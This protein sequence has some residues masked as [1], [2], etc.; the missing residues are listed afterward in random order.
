MAFLDLFK[1]LYLKDVKYN[2]DEQFL[3]DILKIK[4]ESYGHGPQQTIFPNCKITLTNK[5]II[6]SQKILWK[7][8][9]RVH[10]FIWIDN[11]QIVSTINKGMI[12]LCYDAEESSFNKEEFKLIP[13]DKTFITK[14][15]IY[16]CNTELKDFFHLK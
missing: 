3:S 16:K 10:Y 15:I 12:E 2:T 11:E 5:R 14:L 9:Y 4:V 13:K 6:I 1:V 7:N 8:K